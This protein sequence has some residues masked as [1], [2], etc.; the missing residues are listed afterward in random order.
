MENN[1]EKILI[2]SLYELIIKGRNEKEQDAEFMRIG[3][4]WHD[5]GY[6]SLLVKLAKVK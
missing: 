4:C 2:G 5:K 6:I 3:K 1:K